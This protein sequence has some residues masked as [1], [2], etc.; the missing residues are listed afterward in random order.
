MSAARAGDAVGDICD[1]CP[2]DPNRDQ[3]DIDDDDEG[4][5]CDVDDGLI[6][7]FFSVPEYV[8]W[9]QEAGYATWNGYRGDLAVLKQ[10][11]AYT[12]APLRAARLRPGGSLRGGLRSP[13]RLGTDGAGNERPNANPCP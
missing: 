1:N 2:F 3:T 4:D 9:Q 13:G 8:E 11:G 5:V 10:T 12:I 6:L 7:L